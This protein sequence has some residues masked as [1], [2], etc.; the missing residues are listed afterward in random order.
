M[1]ST[2]KLHKILHEREMTTKDLERILQE[3]DLKIEY[4]ALTEFRSGKRKNM[5]IETLNKL[6]VALEVTPNDLVEHDAIPIPHKR[7]YEDKVVS[8]DDEVVSKFEVEN[9]LGDV[10]VY[11]G[12]KDVEDFGF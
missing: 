2:T 3:K 1:K 6:C 4:Y 9:S 11:E 10:E 12:E 7:R 5:T 8:K